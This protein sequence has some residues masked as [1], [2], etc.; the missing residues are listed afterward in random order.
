MLGIFTRV[1]LDEDRQNNIDTD[2]APTRFQK[3]DLL[4]LPVFASSQKQ[5]NVLNII[6]LNTF[7][8]M[9]PI[10]RQCAKILRRAAWTISTVMDVHVY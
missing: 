7:E 3:G 10:Q 6:C 5:K 2:W 4:T 9:S 1:S 8:D